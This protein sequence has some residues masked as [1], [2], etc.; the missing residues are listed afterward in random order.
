MRGGAVSA[1]RAF[2]LVAVLPDLWTVYR[3]LV[4]ISQH[5]TLAL[6]MRHLQALEALQAD[7]GHTS[8]L[9]IVQPEHSLS[10]IQLA[11][12]AIDKARKGPPAPI[13]TTRSNA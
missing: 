9:T 8:N 6:A 2:P 4:A 12:Q 13:P 7:G 11:R 3:G 10:A 5:A 1:P